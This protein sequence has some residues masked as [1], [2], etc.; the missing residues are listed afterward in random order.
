VEQYIA[1]F[2]ALQYKITMHNA[3]HDELYFAMQYVAGLNN[4]IKATVEPQVPLTV[5]RQPSLQRYNKK[6]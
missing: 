6:S 4:D 3:K 1:Q 2:H 5:D